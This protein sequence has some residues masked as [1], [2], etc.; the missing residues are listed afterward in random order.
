MQ[1]RRMSN[2]SSIT[3][4]ILGVFREGLLICV[5]FITITGLLIFVVVA[6]LLTMSWEEIRTAWIEEGY[7]E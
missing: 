7:A 3:R 4:R 5:R 1:H 6:A 2:R